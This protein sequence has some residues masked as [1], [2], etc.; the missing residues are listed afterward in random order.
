LIHRGTIQRGAIDQG[1]A[2]SADERLDV[3]ANDNGPRVLRTVPDVGE[4]RVLKQRA[5]GLLRS[6]R[7]LQCMGHRQSLKK[8]IFEISRSL[9]RFASPTLWVRSHFKKL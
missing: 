6:P 2:D 5:I 1:A 9:R 7:A 4:M 3:G 8:S